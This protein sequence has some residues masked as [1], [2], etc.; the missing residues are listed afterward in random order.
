M[1]QVVYAS[2]E[3]ENLRRSRNHIHLRLPLARS[4]V[5]FSESPFPHFHL[6][7]YS[8]PLLPY[9]L[10]YPLPNPSPSHFIP[11]FYS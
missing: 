11:H 1:T 2:I 7:L 5:P 6:I 3:M 9:K 8:S 10:P 4:S